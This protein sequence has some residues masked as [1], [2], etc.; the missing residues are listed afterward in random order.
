MKP[1][2]NFNINKQNAVLVIVDIQNEFAKPG[3]K[4]GS[5]VSAKIMP[6]VISAVQGLAD[7]A[8]NAGV[9]VIYIQSVR[10]LKEPEFTVFGRQPHLEIGT[11]ASEIVD[12]LK[13]HK[14]DIVVQKF[15]H[16]PF[17][18]KDLDEV[19]EKMVP[20]PT[21]CY[22]IVTGG[23]I[24]VCV[25]HTVMGFHLR[26]YWTVVPVDSVYYINEAAYERA[27]GQY[28]EERPYPNVFLSRS[29]LIEIS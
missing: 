25:Y 28:S 19:L 3:G 9:P 11:W 16:D 24:N 4:L 8:R 14:E 2:Q 6:G 22:A 29:D 18:R 1:L 23:A 21:K 5:E 12:E 20:D 7:R 26:N 13:P 10:T 15:S 27:L 17:Y